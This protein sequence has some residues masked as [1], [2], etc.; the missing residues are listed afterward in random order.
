M[1]KKIFFNFCLYKKN[2]TKKTKPKKCIGL[3]AT[4]PI[5]KNWIFIKYNEN[6]SDF[7]RFFSKIIFSKLK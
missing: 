5:K 6:I 1:N 7:R 2:K 3:K 4:L